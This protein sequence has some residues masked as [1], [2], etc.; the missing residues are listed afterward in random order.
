MQNTIQLP[1]NIQYLGPLPEKKE[2]FL[3][4]IYPKI[5]RFND[6]FFSLIFIL[7]V[8]PLMLIIAILIKLDSKGP[9]FYLQERASINGKPFNLIKLRT[10][11]VDADKIDLV[12]HDNDSRITRIGKIIR[13]C[14]LDEIPQ[15]INILKGDM[16]FVGPRAQPMKFKDQWLSEGILNV[17]P[18]ILSWAVLHGREKLPYEYRFIL[19]R[20]YI[21]QLSWETDSY[22]IFTTLNKYKNI[23]KWV[24]IPLFIVIIISCILVY[25]LIVG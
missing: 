13:Y 4:K 1:D 19:E 22:I 9:I 5:K 8:W 7:M 12:T 11:I 14:S 18:G 16:S 3:N 2:H 20:E 6:I 10:M 25:Y 24:L 15:I 21:E 23:F 17:Q